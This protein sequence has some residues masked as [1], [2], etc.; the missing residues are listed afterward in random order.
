MP[1]GAQQDRGE[2]PQLGH[3]AV[4]QHL[5]GLEVAVAADVVRRVVEFDAELAGRGVED[6]DYLRA[7]LQAPYRRRR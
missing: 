7:R 5:A 2:L 1:D 4:R 3:H 6:L